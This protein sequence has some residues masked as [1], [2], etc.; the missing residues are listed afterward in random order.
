MDG[1]DRIA[2]HAES[3]A[4]SLAKYPNRFAKAL[5]STWWLRMLWGALCKGAGDVSAFVLPVALKQ[6]IQYAE[7]PA[8]GGF[9]SIPVRIWCWTA[10]LFLAPTLQGLLYH[11]FY[12]HVMIDG[13]HARTAVQA[14]VLGKLLRLPLS[15]IRGSGTILNL[16]AQDARAGRV[17]RRL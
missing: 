8:T 11:W 14:S 17:T 4:V 6:I 15:S 13:L 7:A 16:Q 9:S 2:Q 5:F 3:F 12:H 1:R 10:A